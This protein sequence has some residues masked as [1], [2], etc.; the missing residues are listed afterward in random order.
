MSNFT[1]LVTGAP[2]TVA[3]V[4]GIATQLSNAIDAVTGTSSA[5]WAVVL[6]TQALSG[7]KILLCNAPASVAAGQSV[8]IGDPTSAT[9]ENRVVGSTV[10]GVSITVT[11]NLT[12]THAVGEAV[13]NVGAEI[14]QAR[15]GEATLWAEL[16]KTAGVV[17]ASAPGSPVTGDVWIDSAHG[18][19]RNSWNGAAWVTEYQ[20]LDADLT[21][22]AALTTTAYGRGRLVLAA[23]FAKVVNILTGTTTYTPTTGTTALYVECIGGGG[24]G[25]GVA[26]AATNSGA[27]AG[28]GGGAYSAVWLTGAAVKASFMVGVGAGGAAGAAG[29]NDGSNGG[30]TTFDSP[31]VCTAEGGF[32]GAGDTVATIHVSAGAATGIGGRASAGV[33]DIKMSG[34]PGGVGVALAAAQA[35]SGI[36]GSASSGGGGGGAKHLQSAGMD[37]ANYGGGGSGG[38]IAS[39][40]VSV[41]GGAGGP[42]L[43]RVTEY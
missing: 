3:S 19:A 34:A 10:A 1:P 4:N 21:A 14:Y 18:N 30:V 11:V 17:A 26:Q 37:G 2:Q 42:G 29:A 15:G 7:Q 12:S 36:G 20:P 25:G 40:G 31:S 16:R 27:G 38:V 8:L 23:A 32:G 5:S 22:I 41:A 13:A 35:V 6:T 33:G 43:I 39:G 24:G 28:G 9:L